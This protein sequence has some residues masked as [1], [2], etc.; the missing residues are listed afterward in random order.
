MGAWNLVASTNVA[1]PATASSGKSSTSSMLPV[2]SRIRLAQS[3][4][5]SLC[6]TDSV[7]SLH[8]APLACCRTPRIIGWRRS[9]SQ[10]KNNVSNFFNETL[11]RFVGSRSSCVATST[12]C[13]SALSAGWSLGFEVETG[14]SRD[15]TGITPPWDGLGGDRDVGDVDGGGGEGRVGNFGS[16]ACELFAITCTAWIIPSSFFQHIIFTSHRSAP[17]TPHTVTY[18]ATRVHQ[19]AI[20]PPQWNIRSHV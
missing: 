3:K 8:T 19:R 12:S 11:A 13:V 10:S 18:S 5:S 7:N 14:E 2:K 4:S 1:T 15:A 20:L 16:S 9:S 17:N 6:I